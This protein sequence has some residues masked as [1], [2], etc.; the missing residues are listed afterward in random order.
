MRKR[1]LV[2]AVGFMVCA[3][4]LVAQSSSTGAV[5][6]MVR[7]EAGGA[8]LVGVNLV[9]A[10]TQW[11]ATTGAGGRYALAS[12]PPGQY[13]VRASLI[14]YGTGEQQVTVTS[15]QTVTADFALPVEAV[16]LNQLV[17]TGYGTQ[18]RRDVTGSVASVSQAAMATMPVARV[19]QALAGQIAGVQIQTT[20]SQP[21]AGLRIRVRGS[22]S[23]NASNEPLVV[24]DGVIGADL[25]QLNPNDIETV[26]VLKDA[27]ASAIYGARASNGVIMIT[28]KRGIPGQMRVE[29]SGYTGFQ[30]VTKRIELLNADEFA[31]LYMRNAGRDPGVE[32]D[33][34]RVI[35]TTDWQDVIYQKA[36]IQNHHLT[37]R[38]GSGSTNLLLSTSLLNQ[39]GVVRGS[40][41][42]RGSLRFN[43]DQD[44]GEQFRA[45]TRI[46]YSRSVG[47]EVR[48]NDGYGSGG[49]PV[50]M[51]ALRFAPS[52]PVYDESGK[53]SGPL[54]PSQ[55][56]D[57]P[58]AIVHLRDDRNTT[59]YV[60]GNVFGEYDALPGLTLRSSVSYTYNDFLGQRYASRE[61]IGSL[62]I[63]QAN[64]DDSRRTT[65][66]A[67]NTVTLRRD[68]RRNHELSVLGGFTVQETRRNANASQGQGFATDLLGYRRL[69]LAET[70]TGSSSQSKERLNS[71]LGRL[72]YA[73]GGKYL[74]TATFRAD[75]SSKFAANNKWA[76]FPS[77]AVAWRVSDE[78]FFRSGVPT[79][80][81]LKLRVSAG[82]TGSEAIGAY[83]SLASWNVGSIYAIG[84]QTFRNGAKPGRNANPDLKWE[85][86]TQYDA[87]MDLGLFHNRVSLTIDGFHKKTTDLLYEKQ[88]PWTT[89]YEDYVTNIGTVQNR[90]VELSLDARHRAGSFDIRF[91]G[92]VSFV[93]SRVLYL[94]GDYEWFLDGVNG[95]LPRFR[96]AAVVRVGEPLGNFYGWMWD[97]IF[98]NQAEVD[99]HGQDGARV[100]SMKLKDIDRDGKITN[101]DR[102]IL[103]NAQPDYVFGLTGA[104]TYR[105]LSL[106]YVIRGVQG[107]DVVNLNRQGME[108]PGSSTNAL[109]SVLN[110]WSPTNPTNKMTA[111]GIGP[112]DG[113]TDRWIEDGSFIRTQNI[114]LSFDVPER[115]RSRLSLG[116]MRLY[117]SAQNA[118]TITDYSW[119]DPEVSSRGNSDLQLGWDDSSY[120][121]VRTFTLGANVI[122]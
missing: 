115:L 40:D 84:R 92:N 95:S 20:N 55:T 87:G 61:L 76:Y 29:Y 80:S 34:T 108:T 26:D 51:M 74:F 49:G 50:T 25:N 116:P 16:A 31:R 63:G 2:L 91:G 71:V 110:Y 24:V 52:V 58:L 73:I 33:T 37:L 35:P 104:I 13:T 9:L 47:N 62:N 6:G 17:V 85:T 66:L 65:W 68:V 10:G 112:Y 81:E 53:F 75:G 100:G 41:F 64:I 11:S 96:P 22:N 23:L 54:I 4:S 48:I 59:S 122:F 1:S 113:M 67:E 21:G 44:L 97:G 12:V 57:N 32:L 69:N 79:V 15:G 7:A 88:V 94:G 60:L 56:M 102:T 119:Y 38:G 5:Q 28:T 105:A 30:D 70:V 43:L 46:S 82:R 118:F 121:G 8:A 98:Q 111:L 99:A 89:G 42:T 78:P 19:D 120:P 18:R 114:T 117:L 86:T 39:Q 107:F 83:Q 109:R 36:L 90:G 103:G 106:S 77:A 45:G 3:R 101:E 27:S 93:R 72:N 14:G